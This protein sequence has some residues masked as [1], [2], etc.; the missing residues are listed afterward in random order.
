MRPS[1]RPWRRVL[2]RRGD[3]YA[4]ADS[5]AVCPDVHVI[6][7]GNVQADGEFQFK[8]NLPA[9]NKKRKLRVVNF[10]LPFIYRQW[11][12]TY[13]SK[14]VLRRSYSFFL[15]NLRTLIL[16][17]ADPACR[18]PFR[19][20]LLW[21]PFSHMLPYYSSVDPQYDTLL[22]RLASYIRESQG[23]VCG[24]DVGANIGD[25]IL[26]CAL[27]SKDQ[28]LAIEPVPIFFAYLER[29]LGD[30]PNVRLIQCACNSKDTVSSFQIDVSRGT[31]QIRETNAEKPS[32]AAARLDAIVQANP[33]FCKSNF[34]KIDT[35]GY[36]FEV[37]RGAKELIGS[38][39]PAVLFECNNFENQ[40]FIDDVLEVFQLF[41]KAGYQ[42][43]LVYDNAGYFLCRLDPNQPASFSFYLLHKLAKQNYYFD[44]LMLHEGREFFI[45]ELTHFV[46]IAPG[47]ASQDAAKRTVELIQNNF[48]AV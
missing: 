32:I 7:I 41:A 29:N 26:A 17:F 40:H 19:D 14:G 43:A 37:I 22:Q 18:M 10:I 21:M 23:R 12:S 46:S 45:Q 9:N 34:L 8:I 31:A 30:Q 16:R 36:D 42:N 44:I 28:F 38:A 5:G 4:G 35:D 15:K 48:I 33:D 24:I 3:G 25:T 27:T 2:G 20:R 47:A 11:L 13:K 39:K 6:V 1:C